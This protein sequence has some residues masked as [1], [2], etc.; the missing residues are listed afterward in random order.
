MEA[1]KIVIYSD[2]KSPVDCV[3]EARSCDENR[4]L[5]HNIVIT[6]AFNRPVLVATNNI[7]VAAA[8]LDLKNSFFDT[9]NGDLKEGVYSVKKEIAS[10]ENEYFAD[11]IIT[12]ESFDDKHLLKSKIDDLI[13]DIEKRVSGN[14]Y[15]FRTDDTFMSYQLTAFLYGKN[16]IVN[17]A[18]ID[19]LPRYKYGYDVY[20]MSNSASAFFDVE[21]K[22][23]FACAMSLRD[24]REH[25]QE[26]F[27]EYK[28]QN[29]KD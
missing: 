23:I 19:F 8:Y 22:Y 15:D 26:I 6:K 9:I 7:V 5:L 20:E 1:N 16:D 18:I 29:I 13:R 25:M 2:Y 4:K 27:N 11:F 14:L 24:S 21:Y 12:L 28:K 10:K 17:P 3:L